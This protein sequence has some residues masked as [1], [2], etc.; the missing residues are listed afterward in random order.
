MRIG[1]IKVSDGVRKQLIE[2]CLLEQREA[3]NGCIEVRDFGGE[4]RT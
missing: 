3:V 4:M 2:R 1:R